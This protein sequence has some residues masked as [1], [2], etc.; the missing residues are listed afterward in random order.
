MLGFNNNQPNQNGNFMQQAATQ[1][2]FGSIQQGYPAQQQQQYTQQQLM[3]MQFLQQQQLQQQQMQQ[4]QGMQ[5]GGMQ[6][7]MQQQ[8]IMQGQ[9]QQ[10]QGFVEMGFG[11][12]PA[13]MQQQQVNTG[14]IGQT[15]S[16]FQ[17]SLDREAPQLDMKNA[18]PASFRKYILYVK[19]P[20]R[21]SDENGKLMIVDVDPKST[22]ALKMIAPVEQDIWIQDVT[23]IPPNQIPPWLN[24]TPILV[25]FNLGL[26]WRGTPC[27]KMIER[28]CSQP[29]AMTWGQEQGIGFNTFNGN[30]IDAY[31]TVPQGSADMR[32]YDNRQR[33]QPG[34]VENY[35]RL[36]QMQTDSW[37]RNRAP[38][39]EAEKQAILAA[40]Q[41]SEWR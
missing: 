8:G 4:M 13:G 20:K 25:S 32:M 17:G 5:G 29:M 41:T 26:L 35:E 31:D 3:Q 24:G 14:F 39:S 40:M 23:A 9:Q 16:N 36:R 1:Q 2:S 33:I 34:E 11:S 27:F 30:P 38:P 6:M 10:Q 15:Q 18:S 21:T 37:M 12:A 22:E 28:L 19:P 7:P